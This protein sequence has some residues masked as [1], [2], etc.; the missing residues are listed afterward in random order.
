MYA[1]NDTINTVARYKPNILVRGIN[2]R[3]EITISVAG[4]NHTIM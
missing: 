2:S 4:S 3:I 1:V